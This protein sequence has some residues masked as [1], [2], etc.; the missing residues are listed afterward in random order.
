MDFSGCLDDESFG[1]SVRGCRDD[2]DFTLKFEKI[3]LSLI[4]ASLFIAV[5]FSLIV[6]WARRPVIVGGVF[7]RSAKLAAIGTY[8]AIQLSLLVLA[9]IKSRKLEVFFISSSA[10]TF[11]SALCML[12]LSSLEHARSVRPSIILTGYLFVTILFDIAQTRT[13][14]LASTKVDEVTFSRLFTTGVALK[15]ILILLESHHKARWAI[16]W[17][18][19]EHSPEETA[20]LFGLG[21]FVWL[22]QLFL[23]GYRKVMTLDDLF[24][25]DYQMA[26]KTL[27]GYVGN[28]LD[29]SK[30]HG[31][32]HG[33]ARALAKALAV[34]FLLPVGP[35]IALTAFQFCQPFLINT[36]LDYLQKPSDEA[37]K[38]AGYGLIGATILVY[39]GI[40]AS[41]AFYWYL[42]ERAIYMVRSVLASAVYKKTME[43]ELSAADDSAALT[44]M[45]SD[46]ERILRGWLNI[47]ELWANLIEV[48][49]ATWLLSR[50]IGPA[51]V[52][53]LIIIGI[54]AI[55]SSVSSRY[56]GTR[57]KA[58]MEKIQKRVGLTAN[59]I[60]QMKHL[61]ISGLAAPVEESV[62]KM[63]VDELDTGARF[64]FL[65]IVVITF[66]YL[67]LY[68][69]PVL[70]FAFA[71]RTL[72]VT[73]IFTS[74]SYIFLLASPLG[75][76]FQ[77]IPTIIVA[78]TCLGRIQKFLETSSRID[79]RQSQQL[80]SSSGSSKDSDLQKKDKEGSGPMLK[81]SEG[82]YGYESGKMNL[83]DINLDIPVSR[84]TII[85]GPVASGKSTL[86]KVLLGETPISHGQIVVDSASS[87]RIGFCDQTAF[88][89]NTTI[90]QNIVGF[91]PFDRERYNEAI[92]AA[93]LQPDLAVLPQGDKTKV[94]SNGITLS[95]GQKQRVS[96]AR[97]LYL[98]CSFL[99]FD[100]I[101]SGLDADTEEQ[102][103]RRVF[104]PDGLLRQ[105]QSTVVLCTHSTRHLPAADH[106]VA[107][108][109]DGVLVEQGTFRE[110]VANQK[111]V[112]SLDIKESDD[113]HSE[114]SVEIMAVSDNAPGL[115]QVATTAKFISPDEVET[116]GRM[117]GDSGVYRHYVARVSKITMFSILIS[118][119][120]VGFSQNY[121]TVWL[122]FWSSDVVSAHP[123]HTNSY[124]LGLYALFQAIALA[125]LTVTALFGFTTMI[126]ES[127]AALHK[128]ALKTVINAPL[129]FFTKTDAGVV[130]NLF[131]QDMTLIDGDLPNAVVNFSFYF[132][133]S[134]G[135]AA[136]IAASSPYLAIS[137]P[138]L[139]VVLFWIQKFY[140]RTSRQIRLLDLEAKSP[141]Y[142]HFTDTIKGLA[143]FRAFDWVA[144]GIELNHSLVD[145]SQ[146]PA[147]L[148]AMIQRWLAF[149]LQLIVAL[150]AIIVVALSTQLRSDTGFTGASLVTLMA[151]GESL[152]YIV[153]FYTSL[154]TSIGAVTRLKA[155]SQNVVSENLDGED[156]VPPREWPLKG[157]IE[158]RNISAS[159]DDVPVEDMQTSSSE[160]DSTA[161]HLVLKNLN[162]SIAPGEKI[163]I[164]GRSGSGKS[165]TILLLLRLLDPLPSSAQ[166]ITIDD[167]P[168]HKIDR[169]TLRQ[170][171]IAVPQD[172]V[173]LPDGT[174]YQ[175]NLDPFMT[176]SAAEC[177]AVLETVGLWPF[178][179]ERGGL[180]AGI[181]SDMLSQ[182]QKQLFS[183]SRA[184]L[185]R[186]IRSRERQA[187]LGDS[188]AGGVEGGIL[189]LDEVSSSV[190]KNTDK[191]M[192]GII[193]DEFAGY[194]IVMVS[195]RLDMVMGFDTVVVM[196][197]GRIVE[198]GPPTVLVEKEG[199][200]FR[201]LWLVGKNSKGQ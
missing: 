113:V 176:S 80:I 123:A 149:M 9:C 38:N 18:T 158:I 107:L 183:L 162:M 68:F 61:K 110:L 76:L 83:R 167:I 20:G 24:P 104:S 128:E 164:C 135:N 69:S 67:P 31:K 193:R 171:I 118:C 72:D 6:H 91:A 111:Y 134:L 1:P 92:E 82:S 64:R 190:D 32:T 29:Y 10:V 179:D 153:T 73:T 148:L 130:T 145:T 99:V 36:L 172:P 12:A 8:S 119:T 101:L 178:V 169:A 96:I 186:R 198:S 197:N 185:R 174:S 54:C 195:H 59:V 30:T 75:T 116:E 132:F 160:K 146:R 165:S 187:E 50:Q 65:L 7:L 144:D 26:S 41:G 47:H 5:S 129:R 79:F 173:F 22:N 57:Q 19:K 136:V 23:T 11:V 102:V 121:A 60:A 15:A 108:G 77:T 180:A 37:P 152:S 27:Q 141:L 98:D 25:L 182:G 147:Y 105:R 90:R 85:V 125:G 161:Q 66:G 126:K 45:S 48:A 177:R 71:T 35:R 14:W 74:V 34:P 49:L 188:G 117:M 46:V 163:A 196:D 109:A 53:P 40:A 93:M 151:F 156:V 58:W 13:L 33:L 140:L 142:T 63:R 189:L 115:V 97:A 16:Q 133:V 124:Y 81:I 175:V 106:I 154:E 112:H 21:A 87:R 17:D 4:P 39:T 127:G 168:L 28:Q 70:T 170:R 103:F 166:G 138:F 88:L 199:S 181:S 122:R 56:I 200:R 159:Y 114:N 194:T 131:S 201:E 191:A 100:D 78:L 55:S 3:F 86:C 137:Y 184:M 51:F 139:G 120:T 52:A 43:A 94:G 143:T 95:G 157:A 2:F 150:L 42:Q 89:S 155:F 62:Q 84:L 192:Q 44:L